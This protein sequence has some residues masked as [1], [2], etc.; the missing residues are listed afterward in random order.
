LSTPALS[1]SRSLQPNNSL[2]ER[3][4][5]RRLHGIKFV[6]QL[7]VGP[8]IAD[9]ACRERRLILEV[10]GATHSTDEEIAR[11]CRRDDILSRASWNVVRVSNHD[12]L[13][14]MDSVLE[15]ILS[16]CGKP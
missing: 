7:A 14:L 1:A 10:D 16:H 15:N 8:F 6:R 9:F 2:W 5:S 12:V 11:D 4:R 13:T 3:L